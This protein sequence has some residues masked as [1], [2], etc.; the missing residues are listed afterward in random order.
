MSFSAG[1]NSTK[2]NHEINFNKL[3][4]VCWLGW[5]VNYSRRDFFRRLPLDGQAGLGQLCGGRHLQPKRQAI[6]QAAETVFQQNG[7]QALTLADGSTGFE[8]EATEREQRQYAGFVGAHE[9][10]K[11]NIRVRMKIEPKNRRLLV[12]LQSL[13]RVQPGPGGF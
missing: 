10:E 13:R 5:N 2:P 7:Y 6:Q 9:G 1:N 11:V 8:R 3:E 4:P 12:E